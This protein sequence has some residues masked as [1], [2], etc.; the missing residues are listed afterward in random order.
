MLKESSFS[1]I[2]NLLLSIFGFGVAFI[3]IWATGTEGRGVYSILFQ[4]ITIGI[5]M[6]EFGLS[7]ANIYFLARKDYS[8]STLFWNSLIIGFLFG[9]G[10]TLFIWFLVLQAPFLFPDIPQSFLLIVSLVIP[11]H[12]V[13]YLALALLLGVQR[14]FQYNVAQL[15]LNFVSATS[16]FIFLPLFPTFYTIL[17]LLIARSLL[18]FVVPMIFLSPFWKEIG[19][20]KGLHLLAFKKSVFYGVKIYIGSIAQYL[21]YR[22]DIFFINFFLGA[23]EVGIYSIFIVLGEALFF[24]TRSIAPL[25]LSK[26]STQE[27]KNHERIALISCRIVFAFTFAEVFLL[28]LIA[29]PLVRLF[30]GDEVGSRISTLIILLPGILF[31]SITHLL[32]SYAAGRGYPHYM[33][34]AA[35][36]SLVLI[37]IL[38]L[39]LIPRWGIEGAALGATIAYT[40]T[41]GLMVFFF[42]KISSISFSLLDL[43]LPQKEDFTLLKELL[44]LVLRKHSNP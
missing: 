17:L 35:T 33:S 2:T 16:F 30:F 8:I 20:Q 14:I 40:A 12:L 29:E 23:K 3:I 1:L 32:V 42:R 24:G 21:S 44:M 41:A 9:V 11:L 22:L 39:I 13:G 5:V 26:A 38:D 18:W 27:T 6:G 19:I 25:L 37:I 28:A 15:I 43:F 10:V 4:L 34:F 36:F 7:V 31:F